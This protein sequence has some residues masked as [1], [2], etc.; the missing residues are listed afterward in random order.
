MPTLPEG[1]VGILSSIVGKGWVGKGWEP[2][3]LLHTRN[4]HNRIGIAPA[5]R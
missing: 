2:V 5:L 1:K 3:S 4:M